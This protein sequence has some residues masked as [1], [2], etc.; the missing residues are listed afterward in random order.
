MSSIKKS[1]IKDSVRIRKVMGARILE[2]NLTL[3]QVVE[4]AAEKEM[5]FTSASLSKY[6]NHGNVAS[7][8]SEENIVWICL[9]YGIPINLFVGKP[10]MKD[11]KISFIIPEYNEEECLNNLKKVFNEPKTKVIS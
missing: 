4:D 2:L 7:T 9:R 11:S 10:I 3:R 1:I 5:A 6:L 8:L